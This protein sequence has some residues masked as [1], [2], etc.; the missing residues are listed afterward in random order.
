MRTK[1]SDSYLQER[2]A[3][4]IQEA[5]EWRN[6]SIISKDAAGPAKIVKLDTRTLKTLQGPRRSRI[7]TGVQSIPTAIGV[8]SAA[9]H[10]EHQSLSPPV[11]DQRDD[12][13]VNESTPD[14]KPASPPVKPSNSKHSI[15][16]FHSVTSKPSPK[17]SPRTTKRGIIQ[18]TVSCPPRIRQ[19][20]ANSGNLPALLTPASHQLRSPKLKNLGSV[21]VV[22]STPSKPA[23][24]VKTSS[25]KRAKAVRTAI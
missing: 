18:S 16:E 24:I 3:V 21:S 6:K 19:L 1:H 22:I 11:V 20:A 14:P 12:R 7:E 8:T 2:L 5:R 10:E 9:G 15:V 17:K 25:T 23:K 13:L 4:K